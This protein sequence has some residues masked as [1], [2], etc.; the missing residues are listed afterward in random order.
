MATEH[1]GECGSQLCGHGCCP[2]CQNCC[3][4]GDR[5]NKYFGD[6][7]PGDDTFAEPSAPRE[8]DYADS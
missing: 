7:E 6:D 1:C 3:G 2:Q 4:G 5:Q 8:A